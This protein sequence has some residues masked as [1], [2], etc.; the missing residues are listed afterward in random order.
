MKKTKLIALTAF[1][2][3]S[4]VAVGAHSYNIYHNDAMVVKAAEYSIDIDASQ[5]KIEG[6][7]VVIYLA[8][9]PQISKDDLTV[10]IVSFESTAFAGYKDAIMNGGINKVEYIPSTGRFYGTIANGFPDGSDIKMVVRISYSLDGNTYSKDI[11]FEGNKYNPNYGLSQLSSPTNARIVNNVITFDSVNGAT[12]YHVEY[13]LENKTDKVF[14]EDVASGDTLNPAVEQGTYYVF[15]KALGNGATIGD[16][17][18]IEVEGEYVAAEI[19]ALPI[20]I[21]AS[22]TIIQ[23]AGV[24]IYLADMPQ[25][26]KDDITVTIV[27]FESTAFAG[28]KDAIMNAGVNKVEYIPSSGRFYGTISNGFP[29]DSDIVMTIRVM[30]SYN[31]SLY[32]QDLV[33]VG[34][35]YKPNYGKIE[36]LS[37]PTNIKIENDVLTFDTVTNAVGYKAKYVNDRNVIVKE[38]EVVSGSQI[39]KTGL[40]SGTYKVYVKALGDEK[41]YSESNYSEMYAEFII[42]EKAFPTSGLDY[43]VFDEEGKKTRIEGAGLHVYLKDM[44]NIAVTDFQ[45]RVV[46]FT[47]TNVSGEA[48][49]PQILNGSVN[50]IHYI[51]DQGGWFHATFATSASEEGDVLVIEVA[52]EYN[53]E[54]YLKQ[55]R[56]ESGKYIPSGNTSYGQCSKYGVQAN[57]DNTAYR[58]I[59]KIALGDK[60]VQ[61]L[62]NDYSSIKFVITAKLDGKNVKTTLFSNSVMSFIN[63]SF[64]TREEAENGY[65]FCCVVINNVPTDVQFE[66]VDVEIELVK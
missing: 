63:D 11:L 48:R 58:V 49:I 47:S 51:K 66:I 53:G 3:L 8:N 2:L 50:K 21:D 19:E 40:D 25:I 39:N 14:E 43:E 12:G 45:V 60:T 20:A 24:A 17:E 6:A 13:R 64:G 56:F 7:G 38:E 10:T 37:A 59:G 27:S 57:T 52:Y 34:N 28:Y 22:Q 61:D 30:Y 44:P 42:E 15:I 4:G 9:M 32:K 23:G 35:F 31:S 18:Y 29:D 26:S 16:S 54:T 55:L 5:T 65:L 41:N 46:S 33:F 36:S 1:A 62:I